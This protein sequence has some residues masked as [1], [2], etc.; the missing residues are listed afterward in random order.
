[1]SVSTPRAAEDFAALT[2][3]ETKRSRL[4]VGCQIGAQRLVRLAGIDHLHARH[5]LLD[6]LPE[7]ERHLQREV[8]LVDI[9]VVRP[10]EFPAVSGIDD[11]NFDPVRNIPGRGTVR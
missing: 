4:E 2:W 10:G 8:F 5:P 1:M 11:H 3:I 7:F 6:E 9:A